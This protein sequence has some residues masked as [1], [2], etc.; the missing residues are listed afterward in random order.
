M[1]SVPSSS[2]IVAATRNKSLLNAAESHLDEWVLGSGVSASIATRS[3]VSPTDRMEI[4]KAIGWK[5]Y[6]DCNPL[7]WLVRGI[8]LRTMQPQEFCQFKPDIAIQFP[9]KEKPTKYISDKGHPYDAI[10]LP[11]PDKDYWRRVVDDVSIVVDLDEGTKKSGCGMTCGFPSLALPG[12]TMWQRCGELVNNLGIL[13]VPGRVFRVRF[14]MDV[15]IKE[16]V[17]L[18]LKKLVKALEARGCTVLVALWNPELG[19]KIDDVK[20]KHGSDAVAK[21]MSEAQPYAQWLKSIENQI[22]NIVESPDTSDNDA[23]TKKKKPLTPRETAARLAEQYGHRWK[24]DDEQK[25]WRIYSGKHWEKVGIGPFKSLV[26]TTID[27]KNINYSGIEYINNLVELLQCDLRQIRWQYWDRK[28]YINFS[29][30]VLDGDKLTTLEHSPGMG[31]TSFLPFDYKPLEGDLSDTLEALRVNCPSIHKFFRTA[32]QDD[33][34]KMFKLLAIANAILKHRFFDLQMFV[35]TVGAPGSGKG[36]FARLMEKM[37]GRENFKGCQLDRLSDGS[38][39]ASVIDKQ[40]VVFADERKPVGIDSILSFT[41]GDAVSYRELHTPAADAFFYGC[42]LICSNKPIFVGDTTGLE[43]RLCL[44]HFDNPIPTEK[45]DHSI[46]SEFEAEV[47]ALIGIALSLV[48][49]AVTQAIR[50]I[51]AERIAEFKYKEWEMK[52]ETSSTAAFFDMELVLDP[53]ATTRTGKLYEAYKDFCEGSGFSKVSIVKFPKLLADLLTDENLPF[54]RHQGAQAYFEGVRVREKSDNHLTHSETLSGVEGVSEVV[55]GS[56][57]GVCEGV[58]PL[59]D[60]PL[61]EL[62]ELEPKVSTGNKNEENY[63]PDEE[64]SDRE[65]DLG[66]DLPPLTPSTP[67]NPVPVMIQTPSPTPS[68]VPPTPSP[69]PSNPTKSYMQ[70]AVNRQRAK[71]MADEYRAAKA[72]GDTERM[73][74]IRKFIESTDGLPLRGFFKRAL[75]GTSPTHQPALKPSR[76]LDVG[77][78]VVVVKHGDRANGIKG[79]ITKITNYPTYTGLRVRFDKEVAFVREQ[80]FIAGD[81]MY[82]SEK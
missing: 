56:L 65:S 40:L 1:D 35:H 82:L 49:N 29:N 43:R 67:S 73:E 66:K 77:D 51:G 5:S 19:L 8:D 12:V 48:D 34:R 27:A 45:R 72:S 9:E 14:D 36:T 76:I 55:S 32:M 68:Q 24:Y 17:L 63:L 57:E 2:T 69:T 81:L 71:R 10:A 60:I 80:E 23:P 58:E 26:K 59:P 47:P 18:E 52:V 21:I 53:T 74:E 75:N 31:F 20:V 30:C 42:F 44:V 70:T 54:T 7:G 61:R 13:A 4:A 11:H 16:G 22:N 50:G 79:E 6:P 38:T 46:E 33:E 39:K 41:G 15:L 25:T 64:E 78:R 28:R 37:V 62:R 3:I